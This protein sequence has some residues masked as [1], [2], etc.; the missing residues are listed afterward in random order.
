MSEA[1][2]GTLRVQRTSSRDI[3]IRDL[4]VAIDG[5]SP[6]NVKYGDEMEAF[7]SVGEH[8][9]SATNRMVTR[10]ATFELKEGQTVSFEVINVV[11]GCLAVLALFGTAGY[12]VELKKLEG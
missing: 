2:T 10:K 12:T 3:K 11:G 7:L 1:Q 8:H 4:Y 6:Q 9:I 5:G